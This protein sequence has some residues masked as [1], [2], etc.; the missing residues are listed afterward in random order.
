MG[1]LEPPG[2]AQYEY[3]LEYELRAEREWA[4]ERDGNHK[5]RRIGSTSDRLGKPDYELDENASRRSYL[6]RQAQPLIDICPPPNRQE[7]ASSRHAL[8]STLQS[9]ALSHSLEIVPSLPDCGNPDLADAQQQ[10]EDHEMISTPMTHLL[11]QQQIDAP[12]HPDLPSSFTLPTASSLPSFSQTSCPDRSETQPDVLSGQQAVE[13]DLGWTS[14]ASSAN[15]QVPADPYVGHAFAGDDAFARS[16]ANM[17]NVPEDDVISLADT[18]T[19]HDGLEIFS[20]HSSP[21]STG[22]FTTSAPDPFQEV[23]SGSVLDIA[24][25]V[26]GHVGSEPPQTGNLGMVPTDDA[27]NWGHGPED[28][29][30]SYAIPVR[31]RRGSMSVLS[32]SDDEAEGEAE[33]MSEDGWRSDEWE[34]VSRHL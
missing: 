9:P 3:E 29:G 16:I 32:M 31:T 15:Q 19:S 33:V 12:S 6:A 13:H 25:V 23:I 21:H 17:G 10:S 11:Q 20:I 28:L 34:S 22:R 26:E 30:M 18:S 24:A 8:F 5:G 7:D 1:L 4:M 2:L 27:T 14:V